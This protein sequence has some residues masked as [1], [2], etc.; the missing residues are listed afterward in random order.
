MTQI[1]AGGIRFAQHSPSKRFAK[2]YG[3]LDKGL[4]SLV[5]DK[6][7]DL[8]QNPFPPG[9]A[10]EKLKGYLNPEIYT[11]HVTGNYKISMHV[12]DITINV[13]GIPVQAKK[14]MLR[15]VATHNEIDRAP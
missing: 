2:E 12:E 13:N 9:L 6:L 8:L 15:R 4:Q 11:V 5:D 14:A 1:G 10:F 7:K 3:K